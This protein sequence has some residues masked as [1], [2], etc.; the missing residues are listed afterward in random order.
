MRLLRSK[1]RPEP[2]LSWKT[3]SALEDWWER[4]DGLFILF[5]PLSASNVP[6]RFR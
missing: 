6:V 4:R 3:C 1:F 2:T 5:A